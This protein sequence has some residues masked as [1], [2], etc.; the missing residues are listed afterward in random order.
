MAIPL[1]VHDRVALEEQEQIA[2]EEAI[3][4]KLDIIKTGLA[5]DSCP[6]IMPGTTPDWCAVSSLGLQ[7]G[8]GRI[9][10]SGKFHSLIQTKAGSNIPRTRRQ[11]PHTLRLQNPVNLSFYT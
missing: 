4:A 2:E 9:N 7:N 10:L 1:T 8:V 3:T 5:A 6:R 11:R